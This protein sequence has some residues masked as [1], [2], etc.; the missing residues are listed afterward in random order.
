[1]GISVFVFMGTHIS[2][3]E[4]LFPNPCSEVVVCETLIPG[5]YTLIPNPSPK[6]RRERKSSPFGRGFR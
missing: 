1:V 4:T 6:G 2:G 5:I 3:I